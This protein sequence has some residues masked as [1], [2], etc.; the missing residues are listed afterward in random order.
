MR[1]GVIWRI[2]DGTQVKIWGNYWVPRPTSFKIQSPC[3]I[4]D[5]DA[6]VC[7]LMGPNR[8]G[9]NDQLIGE[10]FEADEA[11]IIYNLPLSQYGQED[12]M[13]WRL[14]KT[15]EFTIR[16]AYYLGKERT[17]RR[18]EQCSRV[19]ENK[20]WKSIWSLTIPNST[21]MFI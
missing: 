8:N 3:W 12:K 14:T 9:W 5:K 6:K 2:G 10:H 1:E 20:S 7:S 13:I 4:G 11:E 21:R 19:V 17:T 15:G 18:G 16:S